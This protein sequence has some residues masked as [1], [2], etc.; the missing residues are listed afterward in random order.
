MII[1]IKIVL[2]SSLLIT[3]YHLFLEKEKMYRFNRFYLLFSLLFSYTVPFISVNT[4]VPKS[5]RSAQKVIETTQ[6]VLNLTAENESF[7]RINLIWIIYGSVAVFLL[8]KAI[9]SIV[10]I[11]RLKGEK[12]IY[13]NQKLM[14]TEENISPFSFWN[15]I[16]LG[17]NYLVNNKIDARI[18][19]HEKA[20][21]EQKHSIDLLCIEILKIMT[22][23]NPSVYFYRK[24][25]VT[26]HE[27]LAD[28]AVLKNDFDIKDYQR[29]ILKEIISTQNYNLTHTFNFKNTKKRF[30]MM[31]TKKTKWTHL[32]KAVSIPIVIA[33]FGLF[34][35]KAYAGNIEHMIQ[36]TQERISEPEK[37]PAAETGTVVIPVPEQAIFSEEKAMK[38]EGLSASISDEKKISDTIRPLEGKN[39]NFTKE[40]A[41]NGNSDAPT[42]QDNT[43]L[44]QFP[45][46]IN[47][48]RNK[49]SK[50]FDGSKIGPGKNN[51]LCRA[52]IS[53]TINETGNVT[54]IKISGN[55][56]VFNNETLSAFKKAN[57]N[58][59]WKPAERDGKV[60]PYTLKIPL[61]MSF[62]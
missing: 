16:Y 18:F 4:E 35:Q 27:F 29:L 42:A 60:V 12:M 32:K 21:L 46:G 36:N 47:E 50:S 20:H 19:L 51:E 55:N 53:Y 57:E 30:I 13:Q 56:E 5:I 2:C 14:L 17:K 40:A 34:A 52:N 22:W 41:Q 28:E 15:T 54:D 10:S 37:T 9:L 48:L 31:N 6:Q 44:P 26:N 24:A 3:F 11:K 38:Q 7:T 59:V 1:L 61:T 25:V 39:T 62:K 43:V 58:I 33:A 23:F 45:G 49:I 8:I